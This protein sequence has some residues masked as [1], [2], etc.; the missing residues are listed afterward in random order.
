[1]KYITGNVSWHE[2]LHIWYVTSR[3]TSLDC[4]MY[5]FGVLVNG[6]HDNHSHS[7]HKQIILMLKLE[8]TDTYVT[9]FLG[10]IC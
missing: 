6:C 8:I 5:D 4:K 7:N 3:K 9:L 2:S 10:D 1:M